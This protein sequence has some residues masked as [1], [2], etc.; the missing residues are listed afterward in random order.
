[1][2]HNAFVAGTART[3]TG[4][5]DL[6][7]G[8]AFSRKAGKCL[9]GGTAYVIPFIR[10]TPVSTLSVGSSIYLNEAGVPAEYLI[11]HQGNPDSTLYD[12]S[13]DGVWVLRKYINKMI[14]WNANSNAND[15]ANSTI[16]SYLNNGYLSLFDANV[17]SK[18]KQVK[19]P[20]RAGSGG[21]LTVTSGANGLPAKIF[22]LSCTEVGFVGYVGYAQSY[23]PVSEGAKLNYFMDCVED[24]S[25]RK[26]LAYLEGTNTNVYN[27]WLRSP[28]CNSTSSSPGVHYVTVTGG[29]NNAAVASPEFAYVR[30]ALILPYDAVVDDNLLLTAA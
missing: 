8:T 9:V 25:D 14:A 16:H 26:R 22:L 11:V 23:M 6:I 2:A 5:M 30:P 1:M 29:Y 3:I 27:W 10:G 19:L 18:I 7:G 21:S 15:Y 17:Q 20:Y 28:Y 12:A 24:G 13:C 4:G